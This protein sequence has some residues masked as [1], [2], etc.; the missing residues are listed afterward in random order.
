MLARQIAIGFGIA[1]IFPLLVYYGVASIYPPPQMQYVVSS[2]IVPGSNATAE[3]RQKYQDEQR[4]WQK[5]QH[6]RS[7]AYKAAAKDFAKHLIVIAAPLGVAAILIGAYLPLYAIGTGLIFGGIVAAGSGYWSYWDYLENRLRFAS[8]LVGF[9]ILLFVGYYRV[10]GP[11]TR[12]GA[13]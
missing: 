11:N 9:L 6:E 12:A 5:A 13:P 4:E 8:L 3:E 7:E 1:V 10:A 2:V